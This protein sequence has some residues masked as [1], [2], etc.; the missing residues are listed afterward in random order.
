MRYLGKAVKVYKSFLK[1]TTCTLKIKI[2]I[3]KFTENCIQKI[4]VI[5]KDSKS[6]LPRIMHTG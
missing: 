2:S 5:K 6:V 1:K 3:E 4:K